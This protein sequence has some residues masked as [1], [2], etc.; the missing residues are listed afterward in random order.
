MDA[1]NELKSSCKPLVQIF[2]QVAM[3][4]EYICKNFHQAVKGVSYDLG[5]KEP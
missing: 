2:E 3:Q 5:M 1:H 4:V